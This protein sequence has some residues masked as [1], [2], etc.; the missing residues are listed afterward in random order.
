MKFKLEVILAICCTTSCWLQPTMAVEN[1]SGTNSTNPLTEEA[2]NQPNC[3]SATYELERQTNV[4]ETFVKVNEYVD[5]N[6][7]K[8]ALSRLETAL[9]DYKKGRE[10][11]DFGSIA[12]KLYTAEINQK[13]GSADRAKTLWT[14]AYSDLKQLRKQNAE[15]SSIYNASIMTG[16][17]TSS[18]RIQL[19]K[20][21]AKRANL[22]SKAS[23][24]VV[25][26][27]EP[28]RSHEEELGATTALELDRQFQAMKIQHSAWLKANPD[29]KAN[30]IVIYA[31]GGLTSDYA[32][33]ENA[34]SHIEWW[35]SNNIYP[36]YFVWHTGLSD[37]I[38]DLY[39][40]RIGDEKPP[41]VPPFLKPIADNLP[42]DDK[43]EELAKNSDFIRFWS[44]MKL[45]ALAASSFSS[46]ITSKEWETPDTIPSSLP[47]SSLLVS[48]LRKYVTE[49][50]KTQIHLVG[51]S[52]GSIFCAGI[53]QA[54]RR[55][56]LH[57]TSVSFLAPAIRVSDF[58]RFVLPNLSTVK[59][60]SVFNLSDRFERKDSCD[61][62]G[63]KY[64][65]S[66]L[67]LVSRGLENKQDGDNEDF[68][69]EVPLLG[70]SKFS[71]HS[72]SLANDTLTAEIAKYHGRIFS[73]PNG[74]PLTGQTGAVTHGGYSQDQST[75][76]SIARIIRQKNK[77][78]A[79]DQHWLDLFLRSN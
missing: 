26:V 44:Q 34:A 45:K 74:S 12:L 25:N 56:G 55:E 66:L 13:T 4:G 52:A 75:M 36:V 71:D 20:L 3:Q 78:H 76:T 39:S 15:Y 2:S 58:Q 65:K 28:E 7:M 30:H 6:E 21:M 37:I 51:H 49:N 59:N 23:Q 63:I 53:M 72:M 43:I 18:D 77:V 79:Y 11:P 38:H 64:H 29:L 35:K 70:L 22:V 69:G 1:F 17:E 16:T 48:R 47:A 19:M 33:L 41:S 5:N 62:L 24:Y 27:Y 73:S 60:F 54:M 40:I 50:P 46:P 67:Y 14:E 68:P 57:A 31:H 32:A 10:T 42:L 8:S 61:I 9:A